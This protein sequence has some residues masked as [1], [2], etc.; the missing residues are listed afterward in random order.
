MQKI[1][2]GAFEARRNLGRLLDAV[3][4]Q[5]D[6]VV[7]EK[8]GERLAAIVPI[9]MLEKW[10]ERREAFFQQMRAVSERTNVSEEEAMQLAREA[11]QAVRAEKRKE[12]ENAFR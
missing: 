1:T 2:I 9:D 6:T 10:E 7:I 3:G 5:G 12:Q 11:V 4:F 8:N